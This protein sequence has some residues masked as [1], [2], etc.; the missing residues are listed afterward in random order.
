MVSMDEDKAVALEAIN[1]EAV[2]LVP[3]LFLSEVFQLA[4]CSNWQDLMHDI[5]KHLFYVEQ[6][7]ENYTYVETVTKW[8]I[9]QTYMFIV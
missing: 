5:M 6:D 7:K 3:F 4:Y 8:R 2:D 1:K 9:R